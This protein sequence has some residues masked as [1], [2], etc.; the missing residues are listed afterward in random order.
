MA[1]LQLQTHT[2]ARTILKNQLKNAFEKPHRDN[3]IK[4]YQQ[5]TV[6]DLGT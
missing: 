4:M 3:K 1:T 2:V 6:E 5:K